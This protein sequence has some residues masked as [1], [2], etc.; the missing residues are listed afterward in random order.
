MY[1]AYRNNTERT[2]EGNTTGWRRYDLKV[3]VFQVG[4]IPENFTFESR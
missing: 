1:F 3:G 2:T 4:K